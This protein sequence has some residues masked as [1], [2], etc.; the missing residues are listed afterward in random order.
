LT[1]KRFPWGDTI[2]HSQANYAAAGGHT[3]DL[4]DGAGYHPDYNDGVIPYT[5][6][7]GSF[8]PNA[9]GLYDMAGNLMEWCF[10]LVC[11]PFPGERVLRGGDYQ[12]NADWCRVGAQSGT[13]PATVHTCT[14]RAVLPAGQ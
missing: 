5:S 8:S 12:L 6:P 13:H 9:Y 3:Y 7:V 14:F 4:S 2:S 10:D 11:Y 1:S